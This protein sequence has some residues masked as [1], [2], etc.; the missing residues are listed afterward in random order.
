MKLYLRDN[1]TKDNWVDIKVGEDTFKLLLDYPT[2]EQEQRLQSIMYGVDYLGEDKVVKYAQLSLRY[3]IKDWRGINDTNDKP[4]ELKLIDNEMDKDQWWAF[5]RN[6][7]FATAVFLQVNKKIEFNVLDKKK[8]F[9]Q[10]SLNTEDTSQE[11]NKST[12]SK[13]E[14]TK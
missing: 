10:Q 4:V 14:D 1:G 9:T 6:A 8:L 2:P 7:E 13:Q 11:E 3:C 12:Q 5:V